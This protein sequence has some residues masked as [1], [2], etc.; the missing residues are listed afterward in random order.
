MAFNEALRLEMKMLKKNIKC[1]TICPLAM[2]TGFMAGFKG[3]KMYPMK[4]HL[5]V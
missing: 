4:G 1:T 5:Y 3:T 2:D